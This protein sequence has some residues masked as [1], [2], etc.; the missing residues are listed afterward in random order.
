MFFWQACLNLSKKDDNLRY[1]PL[2]DAF[3]VFEM[4]KE[5]ALAW[6]EGEIASL[7]SGR[8]KPDLVT[9]LSVEHYGTRNPLQSLASV[10]SIDARSLAISPYDP[11]AIRAIEKALT[12]ADLGVNPNVDGNM[13]RLAFPSLTEE[14]RERTVKQLHKKAE[15]GRVRLRQ[16]R[17]EALKLVREEKEASTITEDDFYNGKEKLDEMIQAANEKIEQLTKKREEEIRAV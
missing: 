6:F 7:R 4:G 8:V 15:E 12:D 1:M 13:I 5:E 9:K 11:G 14:V 16:S 10:A 3:D 2:Q 17:D